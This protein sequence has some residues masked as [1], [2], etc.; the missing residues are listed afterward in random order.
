MFKLYDICL[1]PSF[2]K[3]TFSVIFILKQ[4]LVSEKASI[5]IGPVFA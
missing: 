4:T 5:I 2:L 3:A 1:K